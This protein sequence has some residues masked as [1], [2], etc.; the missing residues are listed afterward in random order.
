MS[1]ISTNIILDGV[2]R[3]LRAA[4]PDYKIES[5]SVEQGLRPP[6]FIVLLVTAEQ[7]KQMGQRWKRLPRFDVLYFPKA[8][9]EECYAVADELCQVLEL[10][11]L[12]GGDLLRGTGMSF[13]VIDGVLHF[14]V[15]YHHFVYRETE[16]EA[17]ESLKIEQIG[18]N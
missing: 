12:D 7:R 18:G 8:G 4:Y 9:R 11:A 13:E 17:M 1:E 16:E 3:A 5:K 2:T 6:A 15:S 10:I 14:M